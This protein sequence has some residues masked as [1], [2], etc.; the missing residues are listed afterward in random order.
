MEILLR[1]FPDK[2]WDWMTLSYNKPISLQYIIDHQD[3]DWSWSEISL[4]SNLFTMQ[5]VLDNPELPWA[6]QEISLKP[7]MKWIVV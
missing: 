2:Q 4:S 3:K 7:T 6:W 1:Q 5:D